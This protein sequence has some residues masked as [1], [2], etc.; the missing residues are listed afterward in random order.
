MFAIGLRKSADN[1][2]VRDQ[3]YFRL[4][5]KLTNSVTNFYVVKHMELHM[6]LQ[7][8]TYIPKNNS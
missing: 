8:H 6:Y 5:L 2:F 3:A 7:I 4:N 1:S